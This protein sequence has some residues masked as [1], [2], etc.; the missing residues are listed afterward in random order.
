MKNQGVDGRVILKMQPKNT[1]WRIGTAHIYLVPGCR[2]NNKNY[3]MPQSAGISGL[4]Q[5]LLVFE[6]K[7]KNQLREVFQSAS[8]SIALA[9]CLLSSLNTI[10][11]FVHFI[12]HSLTSRL[13]PMIEF[14]SLYEVSTFSLSVIKS[15]Y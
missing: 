12:D 15:R 2:I 1:G 9:K 5:K 4:A 7:K 3:R 8:S 14:S 11:S 6:R 10:L 13:L